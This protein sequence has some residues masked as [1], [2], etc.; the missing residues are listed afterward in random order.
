MRDVGS[1]PAG[2][3]ILR[4]SIAGQLKANQRV[5]QTDDLFCY[6]IITSYD[7]FKAKKVFR[8]LGKHFFL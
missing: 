3:I 1:C 7:T 6:D 4:W 2:E 5:V 8:A